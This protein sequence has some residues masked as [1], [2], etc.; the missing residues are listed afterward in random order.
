MITVEQCPCGHESCNDYHLRGVG[1]FVQGSGFEKEEAELIAS[2]LNATSSPEREMAMV[3]QFHLKFGLP[4]GDEDTLMDDY[5][6][7]EFRANFM[8]EELK[9][10]IEAVGEGDRVK[11]FDALL[12]LVYVVKGTALFMGV[13]PHQWNDGMQAV[14]SA[15]M[16]KERAESADQSKRGSTFDVIK[17]PGWQGPEE[18]LRRILSCDS[19]DD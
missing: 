3:Q 19:A 5:P 1:K 10:F 9:E 15:N 8:K 2:Y 13:T 16:E 6:I 17:P 11:A 14:Q 12:D 4:L 18:A 7:F